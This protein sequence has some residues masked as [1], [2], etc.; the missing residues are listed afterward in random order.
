VESRPGADDGL[1][2]Y[3]SVSPT[4]PDDVVV[5]VSTGSRTLPVGGFTTGDLDTI[6]ET[7]I[8]PQ[9]AEGH[10][11]RA[12]VYAMREMLYQQVFTPPPAQPLESSRQEQRGGFQIVALVVTGLAFAAIIATADGRRGTIALMVG[13]VVAVATFGLAVVFQSGLAVAC[14]LA[15]LALVIALAIR[16]DAQPR[17]RLDVR[18]LTATPRPPGTFRSAGR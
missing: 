13:L 6:R 5:A 10:P 7:I 18:R 12:I 8:N 14:G 17:R 9:L 16:R 3:A 15:L 4:N 1:V 2:I 11:A